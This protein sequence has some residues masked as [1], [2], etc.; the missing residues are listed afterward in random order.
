MSAYMKPSTLASLYDFDKPDVEQGFEIRSDT[1][2]PLTTSSRRVKFRLEPIGYLDS[3]SMLLFKM[4]GPDAADEY[5]ASCVTGGLGAIKM[6]R[7]SVGDT[8]LS[9]TQE[10]GRVL[11]MDKFSKLDR[12]SMSRRHAHYLG[13]SFTSVAPDAALAPEAAA[14]GQVVMSDK[15]GA[16]F[17]TPATY[18]NRVVRSQAIRA[19]VDDNYQVGILL[20]DLF[21]CLKRAGS[22]RTLPLYLF[23]QYRIYIDI[24]FEDGDKFVNKLDGAAPGAGVSPLLQAAATDISY[25][26]IKLQVDYV[27]MPSGILDADRAE[28]NKDGGLTLN[29]YDYLVVEKVLADQGGVAEQDTEFRIG[30]QE[31]DVHAV[32]MLKQFTDAVGTEFS[33][34]NRALMLNNVCDAVNKESY[35][36]TV[37]GVDRYP[38]FIESPATQYD[39]LSYGV[40]GEPE[41]E[42]PFL[43]Q[44]DN[45]F[46]SGIT[47][48][49]SGL[50]GT[51]KPLSCDLRNGLPVVVGGGT[52]I[53]KYPIIWKYKRTGTAGAAGG[54]LT[55]RNK[56]DGPASVD[57][58]IKASKQA[59]VMSTP[60]GMDITVAV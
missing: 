9:E 7:L 18:A 35:Q 33:G 31:R 52:Q 19:D 15:C 13:N 28:T 4:K 22:I 5:R 44:D 37:N 59:R 16:Y 12:D 6:A 51:Y 56:M 42:R 38:F 26:D 30:A 34:R 32:T 11:F 48:A 60:V 25:S 3:N 46:D 29:Y 55:T 23:D 1:I 57:F 39:L 10:C 27:I 21:P 45:D 2:D 54:G 43:F 36:V 24:E 40:G 17:G 14:S 20:G 58:V 50:A 49:Q 47:T 8:I 53:G 41:M